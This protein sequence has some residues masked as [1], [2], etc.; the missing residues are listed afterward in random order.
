LPCSR[1]QA[2]FEEAGGHY[3][4]AISGSIGSE[5][6]LA[7]VKIGEHNPVDV[8]D[9]LRRLVRNAEGMPTSGWPLVPKGGFVRAPFR[10]S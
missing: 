8:A 3:E 9:A 5:P 10:H 7:V 4:R 6:E 2:G 1:E